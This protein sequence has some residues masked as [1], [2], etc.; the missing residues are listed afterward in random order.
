[1]Q[2]RDPKKLRRLLVVNNQSARQLAK[3]VGYSSHSYVNRILAGDIK[4]V[5][6]ARATAIARFLK[7]DVDDLFAAVVSTPAA[8]SGNDRKTA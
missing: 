3:G 2:V 6:P 5:T 8:R 1:M 4:T 7:V